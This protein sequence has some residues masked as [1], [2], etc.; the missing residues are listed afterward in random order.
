ML[1][2]QS[3]NAIE[4]DNIDAAADALDLAAQLTVLQWNVGERVK[5]QFLKL[6][7]SFS[8]GRTEQNKPDAK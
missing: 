7:R 1:A 3:A 4:T 2:N 5:Q 8:N 6:T